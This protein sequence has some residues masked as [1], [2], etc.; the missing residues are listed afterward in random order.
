MI[1]NPQHVVLQPKVN[2]SV[3]GKQNYLSLK[4]KGVPSLNNFQLFGG[5]EYQR[6]KQIDR[7]TSRFTFC[8]TLRTLQLMSSFVQFQYFPIFCIIEARSK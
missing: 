5:V 6:E 8:F 2:I 4:L 3:F 1:S 7:K